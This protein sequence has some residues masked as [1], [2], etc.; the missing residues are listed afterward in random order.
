MAKKEPK[1]LTPEQV[2]EIAKQNLNQMH[3]GAFSRYIEVQFPNGTKDIPQEQL[4][5]L[6][7]AFSCGFNSGI[8]QAAGETLMMVGVNLNELSKKAQG[9]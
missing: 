3:L 9:K 4:D 1:P 7:S 8:F 5:L 2:Q 6:F